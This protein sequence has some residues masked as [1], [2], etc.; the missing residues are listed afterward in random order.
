MPSLSSVRTRST[1]CLR[2]SGFLTEMTQQIHSLR[3]SGVMSSHFARAAESEARTLR[4]S[5]GRVCTAPEEIALLAMDFIL[6]RW[7]IR[8]GVLGCRLNRARQKSHLEPTGDLFPGA[9]WKNRNNRPQRLK[10]SSFRRFAARLKPCPYTAYSVRRHVESCPRDARIAALI[11]AGVYLAEFWPGVEEV[12][13]D[14][15]GA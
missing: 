14:T 9:S 3:A 12:P 4:K 10:P 1:C 6:H 8:C 5:A 13:P 11:L 7:A 2:V 15:A